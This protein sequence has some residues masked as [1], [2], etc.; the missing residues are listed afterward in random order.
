MP[1]SDTAFSPT[2]YRF[3]GGEPRRN[4]RPPVG[5][6]CHRRSPLAIGSAVVVDLDS[7]KE[8]NDKIPSAHFPGGKIAFDRVAVHFYNRVYVKL[9]E[10]RPRVFVKM[11]STKGA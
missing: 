9:S 3:V 10:C 2:I 4:P 7:S 8:T 11:F 5:L 6:V 1:K